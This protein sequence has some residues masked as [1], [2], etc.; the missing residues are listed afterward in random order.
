MKQI[1]IKYYTLSD[2]KEWIWRKFFLPKRKEV[3]DWIC[4]Y[5]DKLIYEDFKDAL[6]DI[7]STHIFSEE[8]MKSIIEL[9]NR[10]NE[11]IKKQEQE[12]IELIYKQ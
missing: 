1:T 10:M 3:E 8:Q 4:E 11:T 12:T 2:F 9:S 7:C 6:Y 5:H